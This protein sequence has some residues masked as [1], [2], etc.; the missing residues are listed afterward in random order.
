[1]SLSYLFFLTISTGVY[2]KQ[3]HLF[4]DVVLRIVYE[5]NKW[6][7]QQNKNNN[8][9]ERVRAEQ[10]PSHTHA[11]THSILNSAKKKTTT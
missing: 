4:N 2:R 10:S 7:I 6:H 5:W 8:G 11:Q 9:K 1:M 3:T